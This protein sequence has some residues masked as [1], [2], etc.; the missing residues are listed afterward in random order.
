MSARVGCAVR[1]IDVRGSTRPPVFLVHGAANSAGVWTFWQA[2]LARMGWPSCAIDLRGHGANERIDLSR[3]RMQDY[4]DDVSE[5]CHAVRERPV[6]MGWSMG[7]LVALMSASAC[8][9]LA[10]VGLAPSTPASSTNPSITLR[11]GVFGAEEYGITSRDPEDQPA[12]AD[13]AVDERRIALASLGME[14][15]LAATNVAPA[16]SST[17]RAVRC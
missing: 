17:D 6:L 2:E 13:L 14:S 16:W 11:E 3:T 5:L 8:R 4:A 12:M 7:G 10:C 1:R 9:A 15:R